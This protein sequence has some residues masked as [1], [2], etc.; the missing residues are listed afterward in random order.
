MVN[1]KLK[2]EYLEALSY[3][4]LQLQSLHELLLEGKKLPPNKIKGLLG[5]EARAKEKYDLLRLKIL[6]IE[7]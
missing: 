4:Q 5:R 1:S 7:S 3:W 2:T 6:G